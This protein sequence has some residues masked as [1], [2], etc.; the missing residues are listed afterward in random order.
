[1]TPKL[2]GCV[3]G[4]NQYRQAAIRAANQGEVAAIFLRTFGYAMP[5]LKAMMASG[6]FSEIMVHTAPFDYSHRY[7]IDS[8]MVQVLEDARDLEALQKK[9]PGT[10]II[11]SPFCEHNHARSVM[12]PVL[13]AV[14]A[15][16]P[17]C[18]VANSIWKGD[19]VPGYMT[20][21]HIPNARN[22]PRAPR[23]EF[24]ISF[25]GVGGDGS[26]DFTDLDIVSIL[27]RYRRAR[28]IRHWNFR[29]NGKY[30][31]SDPATLTERKYFPNVRYLRGHY[32]TLKFERAV[33]L[34][35]RDD[36][37]YKPFADDHGGDGAS[38]DNRAMVILPVATVVKTVEV[39]DKNDRVLARMNAPAVNP[40]HTGQPRGM[41]YY[42][43]LYAYE[44]GNLAEKSSGLRAIKF[45]AGAFV[46]PL[47]DADLRSGR[48]K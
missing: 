33:P 12:K 41:R 5:T 32:R 17:S 37:L 16:A 47:T 15:A 13:D 38:K 2:G 43:S 35:N 9:Y 14:R 18:L 29:H 23:G 30:G 1:M 40:Q 44:L 4:A 6:K 39:L 48:F 3:L 20:D 25:D 11:I 19:I 34:W 31:H 42:S 10:T 24:T 45:R 27:N 21:I 28:H 46:T 26:G 7:P 36:L 22:L 8:L